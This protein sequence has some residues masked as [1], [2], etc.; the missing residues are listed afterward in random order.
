MKVTLD[1]D[2]PPQRMHPSTPVKGLF[3]KRISFSAFRDKCE[4][5]TTIKGDTAFFFQWRG[6]AG[7]TYPTGIIG[8]MC[9]FLYSCKDIPGHK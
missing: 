7:R 6:D 1:C 8:V 2:S 4:L 9:I 5:I 3:F